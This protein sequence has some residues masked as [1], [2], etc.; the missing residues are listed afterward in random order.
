RVRRLS[1]TEPVRMIECEL[2]ECFVLGVRSGRHWRLLVPAVVDAFDEEVI[3]CNEMTLEIERGLLEI[4]QVETL[5]RWTAPQPKS[6]HHGGGRARGLGV[7]AGAA[8]QRNERRQVLIAVA[9][10]LIGPERARAH[11]RARD[12][13]LIRV[14]LI[15]DARE[16]VLEEL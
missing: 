13:V 1:G 14:E 8:R 12:A 15:F 16:H 9:R 3:F 4:Q 6:Q 10:E 11:S 5:V 2:P 7:T